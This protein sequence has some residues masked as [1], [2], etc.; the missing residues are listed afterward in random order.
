MTSN[1]SPKL[2]W[3]TLAEMRKLDIDTGHFFFKNGKHHRV[4]KRVA[5]RNHVIEINQEGDAERGNTQQVVKVWRQDLR[6]SSLN[7]GGLRIV[8]TCWHM[9]DAKDWVKAQPDNLVTE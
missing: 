2:A 6:R 3:L 9:E 7:Y 8:H 1:T 4:L 5:F